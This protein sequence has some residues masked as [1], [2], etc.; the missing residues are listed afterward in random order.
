[1]ASTSRLILLC[2]AM[3]AMLGTT[4]PAEAQAGG[5]AR[6]NGAPP[7]PPP[8]NAESGAEQR[9]SNEPERRRSAPTGCPYRD[10]KL[11]LIV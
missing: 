4:L 6:A 2:A 9:P 8:S 3:A 10:G 5:A 11:D 1:M 7:A